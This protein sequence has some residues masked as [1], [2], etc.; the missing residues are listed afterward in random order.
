[1]ADHEAVGGAAEAAVGDERDAV[2]ESAPDDRRRDAEHL[3]HAGASLR[4]LVA[5]HDNVARLDPSFLNRG[6]GGFLGVEDAGGTL[7]PGLV[8]TGQLQDASLGGQ[9]AGEDRKP[10]ARLDRPA[11][12]TD[13]FLP[14]AVGCGVREFEQG[15]ARNR[16]GVGD[17]LEFPQA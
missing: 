1:M 15:V 5:D 10:T 8:V 9:A 7:V 6:E 13:D 2:S 14:R 12:G 16:R 4:S 11:G 3:A 17:Q